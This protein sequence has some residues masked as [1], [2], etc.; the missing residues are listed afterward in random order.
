MI[1]SYVAGCNNTMD[2]FNQNTHRHKGTFKEGDTVEVRKRISACRSMY[3]V[4]RLVA[5]A[6]IPIMYSVHPN[7]MYK[8]S[9]IATSLIPVAYDTCLN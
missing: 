1:C 9:L 4:P 3:G 5:K 7:L 2:W 8:F 6:R